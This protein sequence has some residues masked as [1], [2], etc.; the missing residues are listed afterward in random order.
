MAFLSLITLAWVLAGRPLTARTL[1]ETDLDLTQPTRLASTFAALL[2]SLLAVLGKI[3]LAAV[4]LWLGL[5]AIDVVEKLLKRSL[6]KQK[7][8]PSL[9]RFAVSILDGVLKVLLVVSTLGIVGVETTSFIALIGAAGIAIGAA[10]SGTLQNFA[11][12]AMLI[13]FKPYKV[14][15]RIRAQDREGVVEEIQIFNTVLKTPDAKTIIIPN[16]KITSDIIEN[17]SAEELR[18]ADLLFGISYGDDIDKAKEV[19]REVLAR[20]PYVVQEKIALVEVVELADSAVNI[21]VAPW[22][23]PADYIP[24]TTT[25]SEPIKKAFDARGITIPFPQR[26]VHYYRT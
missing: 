17:L 3:L 16:S 14:G 5:K 4:V 18:R 25:I 6:T 12:G 11:S 23:K 13:I 8:D 22:V 10:L 19:I 20:N 1:P 15:D 21:L 24:Y 7:F 2:P 9:S 26:D